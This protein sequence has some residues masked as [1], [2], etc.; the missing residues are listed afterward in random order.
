V[1]AG[2]APEICRHD[3]PRAVG[4][5]S[6]LVIRFVMFAAIAG[7]NCCRLNEIAAM[8]AALPGRGSPARNIWLDDDGGFSA[9]SRSVTILA[10][11]A[12]ESQPF[13]DPDL[14]FVARARLDDRSLLLKRLQIEPRRG[15]G[16]SDA[17]IL[18]QCYRKWREET[19]HQVYGDF[20]FVAWDRLSGR[21]VAATDHL[22]HYRLFYC[23]LGKRI[24]FAT[25][26]S[27]LLAC[28]ALRPRLDVR[29]LGLMA[30]G[31]P[32]QGG[33]MF[34]GIS[35]LPG[36]EL[37]IHHDQTMRTARWW[38]PDT[39]P[40]DLR[41]RD[42]VDEVRELLDQAVVTR[43]RARG[44]VVATLGGGLDSTLVTAIAAKH[45]AAH[46]KSLDAFTAV[47]GTG[48][49]ADDRHTADPDEEPWA[50]AAAEFHPNIQHHLVPPGGKTPLDILAAAHS[51]SHTPIRDTA[52]LVWAWQ[53]SALAAC[54]RAQVVLCG[55][56]GNYSISYAG[57]LCDAS[58]ARLSRIAD[59]AQQAWDRIRCIGAWPPTARQ[60]ARR[61]LSDP[62][63]MRK[64]RLGSQVL[65]LEFRAAHHEE[66]LEAQQP[67]SALDS[68]VHAMTSPHQAA[69]IDFMAQFGVEWRDPTADRRLLEHLLRLPLSAFR[70]GNRPRGL[71]RE[72]GRGLLPDSVR[73]RRTRSAP[74]SDQSAWFPLRSDAYRNAFESI[75]NSPVCARF[76]DMSS[77]RSL[78]ETLCGGHG[79]LKQ[80][81]IAHQALD[82]GLF[83]VGF[84]AGRYRPLSRPTTTS[85]ARA[86]DAAVGVIKL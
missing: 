4:V 83:T 85:A 79:S 73:L 65:L 21:T 42:C 10:E 16:L 84:E 39:S 82:V 68:F 63:P 67:T 72:L 19:P 58:F 37:L 70:V 34:E 54:K 28:P 30:A 43:L 12:F 29:S 33:T 2:V 62:Q 48:P 44:A 23:R 52:D 17:D 11:D 3:D 49:A 77:L 57:E 5:A 56:H 60:A 14:V 40:H 41:S 7:E 76:M 36:G 50:T 78:V 47:P 46:D 45:L 32:G 31:E 8:S 64:L 74:T 20:V 6:R 1:A 55:D 26:L 25:Q 22:G 13:V 18:R 71:A 75:R 61:E 53:I 15:A 59:S 9:A 69:R 66:L 80:A 81:A 27:A 86:T 38:Q 35:A 51:V 24:L